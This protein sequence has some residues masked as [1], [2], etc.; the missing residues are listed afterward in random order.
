[1]LGKRRYSTHWPCLA[2]SGETGGCSLEQMEVKWGMT[3]NPSR[4]NTSPITTDRGLKL[5]QLLVRS[6]HQRP[7]LGT[8]LVDV[9]HLDTW[10]AEERTHTILRSTSW[11]SATASNRLVLRK[12]RNK[13]KIPA[14]PWYFTLVSTPTKGKTLQTQTSPRSGDWKSGVIWRSGCCCSTEAIT[15][16]VMATS[17]M[18]ERR[19]T[20][21]FD[22]RRCIL[23]F[24]VKYRIQIRIIYIF[25]CFVYLHVAVAILNIAQQLVD[26][27]Q[28]RCAAPATRPVSFGRQR[29]GRHSTSDGVPRCPCGKILR[30]RMDKTVDGPRWGLGVDDGSSLGRR[31]DIFQK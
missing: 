27:R 18:A 17:P 23:L 6:R 3:D 28:G 24:T 8:A 21:T 31:S 19:I 13:R 30:G 20:S 22:I 1:M 29:A 12:S 2:P 10:Q 25:I 11:R 7:L 16:T 15:G 14:S 5:M 4:P 26:G 9:A